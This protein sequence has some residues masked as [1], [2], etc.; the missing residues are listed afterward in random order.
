MIHDQDSGVWV[1]LQIMH[2]LKVKVKMRV[3]TKK[4]A[5]EIWR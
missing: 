1:S 2:T 4:A 3:C 5:L